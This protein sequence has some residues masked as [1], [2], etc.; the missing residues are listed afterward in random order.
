MAAVNHT[1]GVKLLLKVGDG[2]TPTE[3]FTARCSINAARGLAFAAETNDVAVPDCT[4]PDLMAWIEREKVSLSATVTGA[5]MLDRADAK[6]FGDWVM[7]DAAKNCKIV[8]DHATSGQVVTWTGAF[9]L[10]AFEVTGDRGG[11]VECS[12]SLASTGAVTGTYPA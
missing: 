2:A 5:G 3:V 10:T 9:H 12:I 8:M 11:K 4:D 7:D 6:F 1:R